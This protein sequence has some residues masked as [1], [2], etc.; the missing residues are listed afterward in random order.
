MI[1][2]WG[3]VSYDY[4]SYCHDEIAVAG[5]DFI[6]RR[7]SGFGSDVRKMPLKKKIKESR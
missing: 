4:F 7:P 6:G 5:I 3:R 1:F 2:G